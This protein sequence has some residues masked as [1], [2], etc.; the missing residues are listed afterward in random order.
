[1]KCLAGDEDVV[2]VAGGFAGRVDVGFAKR[3][4]T[5]VKSVCHNWSCDVQHMDSQLM[6]SSGVRVKFH[7]SEAAEVLASVIERHSLASVS[8]FGAD[9][10][11][12]ADS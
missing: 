3:R 7:Q 1:M 9:H 4:L 8:A 12:L 10:H 5:D 2:F 11:L 6:S